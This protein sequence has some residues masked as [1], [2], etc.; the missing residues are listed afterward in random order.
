MQT[1]LIFN[2]IAFR[3]KE[4]EQTQYVPVYEQ[5]PIGA[6]EVHNISAYNSLYFL[7]DSPK[8]VQIVSDLGQYNMGGRNEHEHKGYIQIT[9]LD[10]TEVWITFIKVIFQA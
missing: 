6:G 1:D 4:L 7:V 9:S 8:S 10:S 3:A 2:L 5:I